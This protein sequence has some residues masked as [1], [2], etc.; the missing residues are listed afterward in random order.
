MYPPL[1]ERKHMYLFKKHYEKLS[2]DVTPILKCGPPGP[3]VNRKSIAQLF[4]QYI[5]QPMGQIIN[6]PTYQYYQSIFGTSLNH[7]ESMSRY[8]TQPSKKSFSQLLFS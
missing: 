4:N 3:W 5:N 2:S 1:I 7:D 8:I 6:Q